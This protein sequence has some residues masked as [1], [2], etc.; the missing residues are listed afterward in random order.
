MNSNEDPEISD[1]D[2]PNNDVGI[3]D[4]P[5]EFIEEEDIE[6]VDPTIEPRSPSHTGIASGILYSKNYFIIL[7]ETIVCESASTNEL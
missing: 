3:E 1:D 6:H 7:F 5:E 2:A 4:I